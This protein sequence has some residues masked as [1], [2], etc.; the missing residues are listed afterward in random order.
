MFIIFSTFFNYFFIE[1]PKKF[2]SNPPLRIAL[3]NNI[4]E[5]EFKKNINFKKYLVWVYV[6][7]SW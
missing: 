3:T 7:N 6:Y 5:N 2:R 4:Q 1:Y